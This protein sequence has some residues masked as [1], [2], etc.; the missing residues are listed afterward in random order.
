MK[1]P[2]KLVEA[3]QR[4]PQLVEIYSSCTADVENE[5]HRFGEDLP[6][7]RQEGADRLPG[8]AV[9]ER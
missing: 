7:S 8:D 1:D 4:Y 2:E 6:D 3:I 5:G 9:G